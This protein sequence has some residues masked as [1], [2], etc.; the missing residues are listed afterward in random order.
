MDIDIG[1]DLPV[2]HERLHACRTDS[3]RLWSNGESIG[4]I[5][6]QFGAE[7][8]KGEHVEK[9]LVERYPGLMLDWLLSPKNL[10]ERAGDLQEL[11]R[12]VLHRDMR[13]GLSSR[14]P[15]PT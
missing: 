5:S 9:Y 10:E 8:L 15:N 3:V 1:R 14:A 4:R 11:M 2:I 7:P 6:P 13:C 12:V